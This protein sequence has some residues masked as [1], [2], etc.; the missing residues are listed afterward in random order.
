MWVDK[1]GGFGNKGIPINIINETDIST[2][3]KVA[4]K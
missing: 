3:S 2:S 4:G 1:T